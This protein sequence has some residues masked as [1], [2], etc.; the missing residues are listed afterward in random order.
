[1]S[2]RPD[3]LPPRGLGILCCLAACGGEGAST[4]EESTFVDSAG[5]TIVLNQGGV[6]GAAEA[7][8]VA[9]NPRTRIGQVEGP[10][11]AAQ[12]TTI[13]GVTRLGDGRIVV[14]DS[15]ARD[16]RW[17]DSSGAHLLTM[18]GRGRGPGEFN[19]PTRLFRL[20]GDSIFVED[21]PRI[22]YVFFDDAGEF[23]REEALEQAR[24][25]SLGPWAECED[26]TLPN[27][28]H[29]FC[30]PIGEPLPPDP[31]PGSLRNFTRYVWLPADLSTRVELGV[32]GGLEQWGVEYGD[33]TQFALHPF[34]SRT[35]TAVGRDP[36]R[37]FV[38]LNPEYS[39]EVWT[40]DGILEHIL[41]RPDGRRAPT[42]TE[43]ELADEFIVR[44]GRGDDALTNRFRAEMEI[45]ELLP[46]IHDLV[47]DQGGHVWVRTTPHVDPDA[48]AQYDVFNPDGRLLGAVTLPARF[49]P[50]E[51]GDDY[52]LGVYR[53]ELNVAFVELYDLVK[54]RD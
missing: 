22:K 52:V 39:I 51:I 28:S 29:V 25:A 9:A 33:R 3:R 45:P 46:A 7:W 5:T 47:V 50:M 14:V 10:A 41:R 11:L 12:F 43:S 2:G 53:D 16:V 21:G 42:S 1:M 36:H 23:A 27:R 35:Y 6:W 18:G 17:F 37:V 40:P 24:F 4:V 49:Q 34:Y 8:T 48:P 44:F 32:Y 54:P 30:R 31:G 15:G 20:P 38:A 26:L 19:Y 13:G